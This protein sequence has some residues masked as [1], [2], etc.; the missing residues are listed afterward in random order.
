MPASDLGHNCGVFA[1]YGNRKAAKLT[2]FGLYAL[3]HRGQESAGIATSDRNDIHIFKGMGLVNEVFSRRD[4]FNQLKG[5]IAIGHNRYSTTG[6]SQLRNAQP[7]FSRFKGHQLAVGH[8]GN[9]TNSATLRN[10]LESTGALFQTTSDSEL[11]LHLIAKSR[12]TDMVDKIIYALRQIQGAYCTVFMTRDAIYAARDPRGFRPL[13]LGRL[14]KSYVIASET[15]AFDL[16]GARYVRDILPG[17]IV[18]IDRNGLK[19]YHPF[20]QVK[21]A[22][23]IFEFIYFSRPDSKIFCENVDKVRRRLGRQLAREHPVEADIVISVPDSSNTAALGFSEASGIRMEIGF[24]RNHYVGRTFIDPEQKIR[25]LD[26]KIKFNPVRGVIEGRRIVMV[27]D[28]I[29]RGTTSRKLIKMLREAGAK[30][31]HFRVS[32]PPI[33]SPC[34]YGIDMPTKE[35]LIGS[36]K[37]VEEIRRYLGADSLG[38]LSIEG[39][40]SMNS[41]PTENFCVACFSNKYPTRLERRNGKYNLE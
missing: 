30:E 38:Y 36:N 11:F 12:K 14:N 33:I 31:I 19:S 8:N 41:L 34:Y 9:I 16:I 15:C 23:C 7:L 13:A 28:S 37:K 17:E 20:S 32:A 35:E 25:D 27:D 18:K 2:Y 24:I 21:K 3:Q 5:T 29:V 1:I 26:V 10:R 40:L 39:M 22:F 4:I 6:S